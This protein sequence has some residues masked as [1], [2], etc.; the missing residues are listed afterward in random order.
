[1]AVPPD[2]LIALTASTIVAVSRV[3]P[4]M[5]VIPL[6]NG[7]RTT[8]SMS[9]R[10]LGQL[11]GRAL[12]EVD[13]A[14]HALARIDE[15]GERRRRGLGGHRCR[16]SAGWPSS[17]TLNSRRR[18]LADELALGVLHRRFDARR[19]SPT[20]LRRRRRR[21]VRPRDGRR[22]RPGRRSLRAAWPVRTDSCRPIRPRTAGRRC[23][24]R[25]STLSTKKRTDWWRVGLG[26]VTRATM[27]TFPG[28]PVRPSGDVIS[29][30]DGAPGR[31]RGAA[32]GAE[33]SSESPRARAA[34]R[35]GARVLGIVD[36]IARA[37]GLQQLNGQLTRGTDILGM[38]QSLFDEV[39]RQAAS[40]RD[41]ARTEVVVRSDGRSWLRSNVSPLTAQ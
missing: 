9:R 22:R 16:A 10:I 6:R 32:A 21:A 40:K 38:R 5:V 31:P 12:H 13:A 11:A 39:A 20:S 17:N 33:P 41:A 18:Q 8:V 35:S 34:R 26:V 14:R 3:G 7:A 25:S 37:R 15:D 4:V 30:V 1:M 27:R 24:C 23:R 29:M 2:G 28:R 19:S 36:E